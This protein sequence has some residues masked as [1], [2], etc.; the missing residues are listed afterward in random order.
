M[1]SITIHLPNGDA[2]EVHIEDKCKEFINVDFNPSGDDDVFTMKI[3]AAAFV[4]ECNRLGYSAQF[5]NNR[6]QQAVD[7]ME[8]AA[9][10]AVKTITSI[11]D[12]E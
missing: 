3:L 6:L 8:V 12:E 1:S 9:M 7:H 11:V 4:S 5:K 10:L 2:H